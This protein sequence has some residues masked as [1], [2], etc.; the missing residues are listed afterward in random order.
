MGRRK[1]LY[2]VVQ[3]VAEHAVGKRRERGIGLKSPAYDAAP[4]SAAHLPH[5]AGHQRGQGL[6]SRACQHDPYSVEDADLR[7]LHRLRRQVFIP[8]AGYEARQGLGSVRPPGPIGLL[9]LE[10]CERIV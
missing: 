5:V 1:A 8:E 7:R 2:F 10:F 6:V 9:E 4:R 3:A